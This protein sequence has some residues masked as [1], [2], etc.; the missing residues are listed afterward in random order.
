METVIPRNDPSSKAMTQGQVVK[1]PCYMPTAENAEGNQSG[2][3]TT[4]GLGTTSGLSSD[5]VDYSVKDV[6]QM[7]ATR[8]PY[9]NIP[10]SEENRA[11]KFKYPSVSEDVP[12]DGRNQYQ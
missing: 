1:Q 7:N 4:A 11:A 5:S 10:A 3:S 9:L 2:V 12:D 6:N 8:Q